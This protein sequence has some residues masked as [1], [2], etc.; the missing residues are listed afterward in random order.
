M[1][2]SGNVSGVAGI[3]TNDKKISK[4]ENVNK[5][6][7]GRDDIKISSKAKDYSIA[8]NALK[9][10]PDVRQDR[11]DEVA[12]KLANKEYDESGD[13]IADKILNDS[14]EASI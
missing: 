5:L 4:V 2:I 11:V 9:N 10:I 7:L 8:M 3:Y 1:R 6:N 13:D 12:K 14:F